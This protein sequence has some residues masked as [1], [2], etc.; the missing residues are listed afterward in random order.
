M[1]IY[2]IIIFVFLIA[3]PVTSQDDEILALTSTMNKVDEEFKIGKPPKNLELDDFYQ[4]HVNVYG[5][6]I[7][8]SHRVPDSAIHVACGIIEFMTDGLPKEVLE[9][10]QKKNTCVGI[11]ARYEGTTDIPEHAHLA[12]DTSLNW[13]VRAR[14]LG[15][16]LELPLTTCAEENLLCYQIDKY[17]AEDILIHEFAHTIHDVGILPLKPDFNEV[18]QEML[19][20]ALANGKYHNTYAATNVWEYWAEGVQN[21]FN[22]NADV[23]NPDGKHNHVNTRSEMKVY[24]PDLYDLVGEYFP[25]FDISECPSCHI[26]E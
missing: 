10:M 8:S 21:W 11:M 12:S 6:H 26:T 4:K 9:Q 17:H 16:T 20:A 1:K 25:D 22:V 14:G 3:L 24:D 5:I 15:G 2:L 7:I 19:D 23:P 18:L 13:D